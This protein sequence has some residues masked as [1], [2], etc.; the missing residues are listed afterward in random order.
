MAVTVEW[1]RDTGAK[2]G[3]PAKGAKRE[4]IETISWSAVDNATA[5]SISAPIF[6][7]GNSHS[8]YVCAKFGGTFTRVS[9]V[10]ISHE[11]GALPAGTKLVG[12]VTSSY[13][14][15]VATALPGAEDMS[16]PKNVANGM[17]MKLGADPS[18]AN[19]DVITSPG[20]TQ[21][22][23]TQI[24]TTPDAVSGVSPALKLVLSWIEVA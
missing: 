15:P 8:C 23:A 12:K 7:G 5:P 16:Q 11:D 2:T 14:T 1:Y 17:P 19:A 6:A 9:S 21:W 13:E 3:T 10:K 22:L 20:Y 24:Q 18:T 4:E